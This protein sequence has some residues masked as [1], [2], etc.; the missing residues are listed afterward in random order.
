MPCGDAREERAA[1]G[2]CRLMQA[3]GGQSAQKE[4]RHGLVDCLAAGRCEFWGDAAPNDK[5]VG[6][7]DRTNAH[8]SDL[9]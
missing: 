3:D 1:A 2:R 7:S 4:G 8:C 6:H 9:V 5:I